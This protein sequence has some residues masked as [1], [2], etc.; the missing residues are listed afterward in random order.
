MSNDSQ[1][2]LT[3]LHKK[4]P[5]YPFDPNLDQEFV[6]ELIEDFH[7]IDILEETK[8]FR[9]FYNNQ[10]TERLSNVRLGLRRWI[11][12]AWTRKTTA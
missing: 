3:Y 1:D 2:I 5:Q 11:A 10:P 12:N 8:A 6:A 4:V 7:H 9:W